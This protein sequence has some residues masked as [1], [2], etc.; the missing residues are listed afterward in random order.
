MPEAMALADGAEAGLSGRYRPILLVIVAVSLFGIMDGLGRFLSAEFSVLQLL[1]ARF[2]FAIPVVLATTAPA[3]WPGLLRSGQP[4]L[5]AGRALLPLIASGTVL[6][7]LTLMPL[8]D[9]TAIT[10]AAPLF[11]IALSR[12]ILGERVSMAAWASVGLGFLGVLIVARPG[13]G[14]FTTAALFPLASALLYGLYQVL[15]RLVSR[16]DPPATTLAWTIAVGV[17][18]TTPLLPFDWQNGSLSGWLLIASTGVMFGT[19]HL[20]LIRAFA[21]APAAVLTPF[22][23]TQMV[24]AVLFGMLVLGE[25]PDPWTLAGTALIVLAGFYVL[26]APRPTGSRPAEAATPAD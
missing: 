7:G 8:A 25:L 26:R 23:Y 3:T 20:L 19:S 1:W 24:A 18:L 16:A 10:F 5:Q 14:T 4:T 15:T 2:V 21:A 6:V 12:P 22:T 13:L 11:V 9:V 17:V